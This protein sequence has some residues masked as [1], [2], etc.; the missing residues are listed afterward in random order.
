MVQVRVQLYRT[1]VQC[2]G[3]TS[4][5]LLLPVLDLVLVLV[6]MFPLQVLIT[7][8]MYMYQYYYY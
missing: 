7:I 2:T 1:R 8:Y 4:K 6:R 3:T 5:R